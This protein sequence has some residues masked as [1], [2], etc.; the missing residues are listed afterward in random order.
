MAAN[1]TFELEHFIPY[2]LSVLANTV[3]RGIAHSYLE[4]FGIRITE[5]RVIAVLGPCP[6]LTASE[7]I[8]RTAMEKVPISRAVSTLMNAGLVVGTR[9]PE[10]RRCRR[11]R[12]SARGQT[13]FD[14]I[15]PRA[16]AYEA[17]L[18]QAISSEE[19]RQLSQLLSS[20]Q[21]RANNLNDT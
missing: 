7:I 12:L 8:R 21:N 5:W 17:A 10:D 3:S 19:A 6:G 2:R 13:V 16:L 15:I 18:L 1:P 14:E 9:D 11:L 4:R 20:L